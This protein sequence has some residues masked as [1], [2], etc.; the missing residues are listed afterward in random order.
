MIMYDK[1]ISVQ[2][3]FKIVRKQ[4]SFGILHVVYKV[5]L[6]GPVKKYLPIAQA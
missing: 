4:P 5:C 2:L 6:K 3:N 1:H